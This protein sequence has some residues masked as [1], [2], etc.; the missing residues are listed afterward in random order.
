MDIYFMAYG[1]AP[2]FYS[3]RYLITNYLKYIK[4]NDKSEKYELLSDTGE[5]Y[6]ISE[7][8]YG[9]TIYSPKPINLINHLDK[10]T[11]IDYL[12]LRSNM[13]DD[14]EYDKMID[15]YIKKDK[16]KDEYIGF[17]D[18]KTIYRVK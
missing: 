6:P 18:K 7:E 3:R 5:I 17:F 2:I 1:Y 12:V 15:K 8:A 4:S 14:S 11:N 9:T 13:I 10:L 16:V